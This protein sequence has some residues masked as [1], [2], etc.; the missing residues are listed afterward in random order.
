MIFPAVCVAVV[1]SAAAW[2][3]EA[4]APSSLPASFPTEVQT[5]KPIC[6]ALEPG[7]TNGNV[8]PLVLLLNFADD[9]FF[10]LGATDRYLYVQPTASLPY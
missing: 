3:Q 9:F 10:S 8:V 6:A 1:S 7:T 5:E 2:G 4:L